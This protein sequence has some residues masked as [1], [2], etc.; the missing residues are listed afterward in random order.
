MHCEK[1]GPVRWSRKE[2]LTL[3]W[4]VDV[5]FGKETEE[6]AALVVIGLDNLASD[7]SCKN[8]TDQSKFPSDTPVYASFLTPKDGKSVSMKNDYY[9]EHTGMYVLRVVACGDKAQ[10]TVDL[11]MDFVNPYGYLPGEIWY[12]IPM[13]FIM[14]VISILSFICWIPFYLYQL[15]KN[16]PE[17]LTSWHHMGILLANGVLIATCTNQTLLLVAVNQFGSYVIYRT[18]TIISIIWWA[19]LAA[20]ASVATVYFGFGCYVS[21]PRPNPSCW[22]WMAGFGVAFLVFHMLPVITFETNTDAIVTFVLLGVQCFCA[23]MLTG[24]CYFFGNK[25]RRS[26]H[27]RG[28]IGKRNFYISFILS[29]FLSATFFTIAITIVLMG[30]AAAASGRSWEAAFVAVVAPDFYTMLLLLTISW[31]LYPGRDI[32]SIQTRHGEVDMEGIEVVGGSE[33]AVGASSATVLEGAGGAGGTNATGE[34]SSKSAEKAR[35]PSTVM[36]VPTLDD[37][38]DDDLDEQRDTA[39]LLAS[40]HRMNPALMKTVKRE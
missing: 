40:S 26:A 3:V 39:S 29:E 35:A 14:T 37:D 33:S 20:I 23:V 12:Q 21:F 22:L 1:G 13:Y 18:A 28:Q 34:S 30:L 6:N 9:V 4:V 32:S 31:C 36:S 16:A 17:F 27:E 15:Y 5:E 38:D 10:S 19:V 2:I 11:N 8:Y 7:M 25:M 24:F